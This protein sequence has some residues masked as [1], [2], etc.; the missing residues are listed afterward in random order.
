MPLS[1]L[2]GDFLNRLRMWGAST[3]NLTASVLAHRG[4]FLLHGGLHAF[5]LLAEQLNG[6]NEYT[7]L[8]FNLNLFN[9]T[10]KLTNFVVVN[11]YIIKLYDFALSE[12]NSDMRKFC[13]AILA[14]I[15]IIQISI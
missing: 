3:G 10:W 11:L 1:L 14:L 6:F 4:G 8:W 2:L 13:S 7:L 15:G 12:R 5:N 9:Q